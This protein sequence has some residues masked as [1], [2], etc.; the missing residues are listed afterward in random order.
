MNILMKLMKEEVRGRQI[1]ENKSGSS[2]SL[3]LC[4]LINIHSKAINL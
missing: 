1:F 4:M 3:T 2:L